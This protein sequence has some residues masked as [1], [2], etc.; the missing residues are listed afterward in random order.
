MR[1]RSLRV[2]LRRRRRRTSSKS[3]AAAARGGI[4]YTATAIAPATG[5]AATA[6]AATRAV[7][8]SD[9]DIH[10]TA[11]LWIQQHGNKAMAKA[12]EMVEKM[13]RR[14]DAD[15]ADL[16][17]RIIAAVGTLGTPPTAAWHRATAAART[18]TCNRP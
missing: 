12:R 13:R 3:I 16:W 18:T 6:P 2:A 4:G 15:D 17:M 11:H 14:G 5:S 8:V 1:S 10:R 7:P 9:L